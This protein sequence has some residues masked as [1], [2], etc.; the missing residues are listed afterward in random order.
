VKRIVLEAVDE[1]TYR[2]VL[3]VPGH[4]LY[5][6]H[7][8]TDGALQLALQGGHRSNYFIGELGQQRFARNPK[9]GLLTNFNYASVMVAYAHYVNVPMSVFEDA[10]SAAQATVL[11]GD[12]RPVGIFQDQIRREFEAQLAGVP[13]TMRLIPRVLSQGGRVTKIIA[14]D[15]IAMSDVAVMAA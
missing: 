1:Q 6:R 7:E 8:F 9:E 5:S 2:C 11:V 15:L 14:F 12:V 3:Y 10:N 4:P 13:A